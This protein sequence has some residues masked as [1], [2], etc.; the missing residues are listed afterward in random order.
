MK[1]HNIVNLYKMNV[2]LRDK[3]NQRIGLEYY[4]LFSGI[5]YFVVIMISI[6][7]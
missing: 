2:I 7:L 6:E 3:A 4:N 5:F 1:K